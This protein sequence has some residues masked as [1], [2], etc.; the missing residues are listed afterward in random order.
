MVYEIWFT[1]LAP[2]I[3]SKGEMK[4]EMQFYQKQ[5][6]QTIAK[7]LGYTFKANHPVAQ[8]VESVFK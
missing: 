3:I 7:L 8:E 6:A 4:A 2:W 1:I 5:F